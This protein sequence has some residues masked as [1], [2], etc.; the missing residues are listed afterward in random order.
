MISGI[1][2]RSYPRIAFVMLLI[3]F[4]LGFAGAPRTANTPVHRTRLDIEYVLLHRPYSRESPLECKLFERHFVRIDYREA[5]RH[6]SSNAARKELR[7]LP[8]KTMEEAGIAVVRKLTAAASMD[9][10][11]DGRI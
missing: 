1:F 3:G 7:T 6:Y 10:G 4:I 9:S 11:C 2:H 5:C 8:D